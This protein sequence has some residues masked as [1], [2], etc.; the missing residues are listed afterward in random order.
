MGDTLLEGFTQDQVEV[1]LA[2]E[3]GHQ[4]LGHL[5]KMTLLQAATMTLALIS[6]QV[7]FWGPEAYWGA[8]NLGDLSNLP[9]VFLIS[10]LVLFFLSPA[11]NA[12]SRFWE[13]QADLFSLD[14]TGKPEAFVSFME[15]VAKRNL[16]DKNPHPLIEFLFYTHP[17]ISRRISLAR[18]K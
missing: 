17:S 8:G 16:A 11:K 13:R 6:L 5:W 9:L 7:F 1:V 18:G 14:L 15:G 3:M 10:T 12:F 2:H 4:Q